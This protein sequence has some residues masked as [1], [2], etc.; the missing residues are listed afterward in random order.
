MAKPSSENQLQILNLSHFIKLNKKS[1]HK[2]E[3][4]Q[5]RA[6]RFLYNDDVSSY[7]DI[8]IT[9][10]SLRLSYLAGLMPCGLLN[11]SHSFNLKM[12]NEIILQGVP[13]GPFWPE[14]L[15]F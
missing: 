4:V 3:K 5:E 6:L 13:R 9:F 14:A 11:H 1:M 8:N 7:N 10:P 15:S 12:G 2:I